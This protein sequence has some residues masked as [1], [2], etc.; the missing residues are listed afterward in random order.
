MQIRLSDLLTA[1]NAIR[2]ILIGIGR[3]PFHLND[4]VVNG[5]QFRSSPG[6][7]LPQQYRLIID[8]FTAL[9]VDNLATEVFVLQQIE[10]VQAH[11]ILEITGVFWF[12]PVQ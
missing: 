12:F 3:F 6:V 8:E 4:A 9:R 7:M 10:E 11:W 2:A 5:K 1:T